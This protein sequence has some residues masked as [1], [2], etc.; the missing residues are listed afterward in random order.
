MGGAVYDPNAGRYLIAGLVNQ[1]ETTN[2]D[3]Q[4]LQLKRYTPAAMK[5]ISGR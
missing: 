1:E 2:Y 3:A 5:R 4:E